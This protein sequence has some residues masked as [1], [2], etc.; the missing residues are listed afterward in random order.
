MSETVKVIDYAYP[1]M[2]AEKALREIHHLMLD[3]KCDLALT[4][5]TKAFNSVALMMAAIIHEQH[6]EK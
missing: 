5:C 1:C 2:M 3:K 4:E 6:K